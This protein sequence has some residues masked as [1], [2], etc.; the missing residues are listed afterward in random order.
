M[1]NFAPEI[2]KAHTQSDGT[3]LFL[4]MEKGSVAS[5]PPLI[6]YKEIINN[7]QITT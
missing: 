7:N 2:N 3:T 5:L 4:M 1:Y 6:K